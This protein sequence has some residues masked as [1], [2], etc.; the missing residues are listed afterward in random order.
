LFSISLVISL[1][2]GTNNPTNYLSIAVGQPCLCHTMSVEPT[3]RRFEHLDKSG[4]RPR[5]PVRV[6]FVKFATK[7]EELSPLLITG[8]FSNFNH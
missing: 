8:N 1:I 4:D 6:I 5:N 2:D 3:L 7:L